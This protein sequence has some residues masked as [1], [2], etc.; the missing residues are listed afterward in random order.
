VSENFYR[1]RITISNGDT[2]SAQTLGLNPGD[3]FFISVASVDDRGHES[4]FAYP[5]VRCDSNSCVVPANAFNVT[6]PL[7]PAKDDAEDD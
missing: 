5:E 2:V 4:L 1:Q 7:P 6:A 3:S